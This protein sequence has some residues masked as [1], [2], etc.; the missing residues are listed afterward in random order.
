MIFSQYSVLSTVQQLILKG[1]AEIELSGANYEPYLLKQLQQ[2]SNKASFRIHNYFPPSEIPFV[3]NLASANEDIAQISLKHART[4]MEWAVELNSPIYSFHAG[5]LF[6]PQ[7]EE[8]G[9]PIKKYPLQDRDQ[10]LQRF[11]ERV[12]QL[13][14]IAQKHGIQLLIENNV[15][16]SKNFQSF[17]KDP[18]LMTTSEEAITIMKNTPDNVN[19]MIDVAHLKVSSHTLK[20]DPIVMLRDCK[21]WIKAYH[22]SDN[23]GIY[24]SNERIRI[25]SWFWPYLKRDLDYYS[26]EI[27]H[28][29]METLLQQKELVQKKLGSN[30][31]NS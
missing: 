17:G 24:D 12:S 13:S 1:C 8:L 3:F 2:L 16:S 18:F 14:D 15:I 4:A 7:P 6:D 22:F 29:S 10:G 20:Y 21:Q 11:L 28:V 31:F 27:Y 25:D 19:L 26:L 5:I 30:S 9:R 23:D